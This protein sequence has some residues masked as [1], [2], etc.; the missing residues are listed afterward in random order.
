MISAAFPKTLVL[1][2]TRRRDTV[3]KIPGD[4]RERGKIVE[5]G[6]DK[7]KCRKR[8]VLSTHL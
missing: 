6:I 4:D 8:R 1:P 2:K 5:A 7:G 3:G